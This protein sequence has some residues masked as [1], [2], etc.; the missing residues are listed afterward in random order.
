[1]A[2][3]QEQQ[4]IV[5]DVGRLNEV[6]VVRTPRYNPDGTFHSMREQLDFSN[7]PTMAEQHTAHLTNIN[8]LMEKYQ[9]DEL[10][11]YI[12][13]RNAHRMEIIGH[14]FSKEPS[15]QDGR[16]FVAQ[17]RQAFDQLPDEIKTQF[18][19][20]VEF[21][22]FIDNPANV[23][24]MLRMGILTQ[25]QIEEVKIP[26]PIEQAAEAIKNESNKKTKNAA[27]N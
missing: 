14:D 1:M 25:K 27:E 24:K 2:K 9:P 22:K 26:D 7:C 19:N 15:L 8:Y 4:E 5:E 6:I 13:A 12:A 10:A 11:A 20:H 17:S 3:K 16:N 23:E 21:L 18:K